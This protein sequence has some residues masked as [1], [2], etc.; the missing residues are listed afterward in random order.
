MLHSLLIC[1]SDDH[2]HVVL[3]E[4]Y[5]SRSYDAEASA[6][7]GYLR[8]HNSFRQ[9]INLVPDQKIMVYEYLA[10]NLHAVL[11]ARSQRKLEKEEV[12][13]VAKVVLKGLVTM[14]EEGIAHTGE[15]QTEIRPQVLSI[16]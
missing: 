5:D 3:K 2:Q 1:G 8:G 13:R 9:L 10:D 4:A 6:L 15:F 14:H 12:K 11:Y 16:L 7:G